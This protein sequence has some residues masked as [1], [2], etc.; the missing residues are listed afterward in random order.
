MTQSSTSRMWRES[1]QVLRDTLGMVDD[2][3]GDLTMDLVFGQLYGREHK[4]DLKTR[5]L[6]IIATLTALHRPEEVKTHLS[7]AFN[8]GWTYEQLREIMII[9][10]LSGGW[11]SVADTLRQLVGW[12][13]EREMPLAPAGARRPDYDNIDWYETGAAKCRGLFGKELWEEFRGALDSL[14]PDLRKW[15][16]ANLFGRMLTR[17]LLDDHTVCLCLATAFAAKRSPQMLRIF[18]A[19]A[20]NSGA[21][22]DEIKELMFQV[23]IYAGQGATADAI[24]V[25]REMSR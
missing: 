6:C 7:A 16:V 20:I 2:E 12:C 13:M 8:L 23:G 11:P 24:A 4:I 19:A 15:S 1:E 25:W 18:I 9:S 10:V 3:F 5:E 21:T 17:G 22:A 14:D